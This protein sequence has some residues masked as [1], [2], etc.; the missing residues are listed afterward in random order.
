MAFAAATVWNLHLARKPCRCLG[1]CVVFVVNN[2]TS[3]STHDDRHAHICVHTYIRA[4]NH[5]HT[6]TLAEDEQV[7]QVSRGD[8]L[9][10]QEELLTSDEAREFEW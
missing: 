10:R 3:G 6:H 2:D 8:E 4:H 1:P 7:A 5:T 9:R